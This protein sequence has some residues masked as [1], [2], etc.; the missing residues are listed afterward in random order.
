MRYSIRS[1]LVRSCAALIVA[2]A[3]LSSSAAAQRNNPQL[4]EISPSNRSGFWGGFG[5]GVG[6]ESFDVLHDGLGYSNTLY[7]PTVSLKLGGTAGSHLRLGGE[8]FA[9]FDQEGDVLQTVS[10]LMVIAQVYPA[11]DAGFFLKG[12]AGLGRNGY[13][14]RGGYGGQSDLGIAGDLGAGWEL[15]VARGFYLVPTVDLMVHS[16]S[17]RTFLTYRERIVNFGLSVV[18]Q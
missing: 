17:G 4:H 7:K 9:W 8:V 12:G 15:R 6:G 10:S 11:A 5:L 3:A 16:Y 13:D 1:S 2:L 14:F 18:F